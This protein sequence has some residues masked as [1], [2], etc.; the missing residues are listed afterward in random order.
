MGYTEAIE[1][2]QAAFCTR[3]TTGSSPV[4]TAQAHTLPLSSSSTRQHI[5]KEAERFLFLPSRVFVLCDVALQFPFLTFSWM[6][7]PTWHA[8]PTMLPN[9]GRGSSH[10]QS[11][12]HTG[13]VASQ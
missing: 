2:I 12:W 11:H 9:T 8:T 6:Y 10:R 3:E 1:V 5:G 7:L 4:T 13:H